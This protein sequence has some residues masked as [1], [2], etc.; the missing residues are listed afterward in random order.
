MNGNEKRD[1]VADIFSI[2]M[3]VNNVKGGILF[4]ELEIRNCLSILRKMMST[5]FVKVDI[6]L[7]REPTE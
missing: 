6:G 7:S 2:P 3:K 4:S 5:E 1:G